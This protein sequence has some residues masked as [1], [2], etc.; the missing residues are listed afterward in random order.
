MAETSLRQTA[1]T[2]I[3]YK[4]LKIDSLSIEKMPEFPRNRAVVILAERRQRISES[5]KT[6]AGMGRFSLPN[7][8]RMCRPA[9]SK[10]LLRIR[11]SIVR[12]GGST[13][14]RRKISTETSN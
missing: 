9:V 10:V 12:K 5:S 6:P 3:Q 1:S 11:I 13:L 4:L 7:G 14:D 2:A 8:R